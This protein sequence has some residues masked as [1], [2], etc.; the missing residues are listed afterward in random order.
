MAIALLLQ[1]LVQVQKM[2]KAEVAPS[3]Q[4]PVVVFVVPGVLAKDREQKK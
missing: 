4:Y 3:A 2:D 1:I